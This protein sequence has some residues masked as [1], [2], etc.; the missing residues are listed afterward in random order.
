MNNKIDSLKDALI[1][2]ISIA[3]SEDMTQADKSSALDAIQTDYESYLEDALMIQPSKYGLHGF[4]QEQLNYITSI[5]LVRPS[6][7]AMERCLRT[8]AEWGDA[9]MLIALSHIATE[10]NYKV[11]GIDMRSNSAKLADFSAIITQLK[12]GET[13]DALA[14][15]EQVSDVTNITVT[16]E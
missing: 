13:D 4:T 1:L 9:S 7:E 8:F 2:A 10:M 11:S 16:V 6:S 15:L 5:K 14:L 3:E 12:T